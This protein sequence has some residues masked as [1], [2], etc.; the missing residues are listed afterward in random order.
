[1]DGLKNVVAMGSEPSHVSMWAASWD[2]WGR[3]GSLFGMS[4]IYKYVI[5]KYVS[6]HKL[7]SIMRGV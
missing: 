1:M 6:V 3:G 5:D 4:V 7:Y 2:V